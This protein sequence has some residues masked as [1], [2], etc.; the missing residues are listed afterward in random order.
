MCVRNGSTHDLSATV[1]AVIA[2]ARIIL[3]QDRLVVAK[4]PLAAVPNRVVEAPPEAGKD[5]RVL[6]LDIE[7]QPP[8]ENPTS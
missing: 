6:V 1:V 8:A 3:V 4:V 5:Q 2:K 7:A